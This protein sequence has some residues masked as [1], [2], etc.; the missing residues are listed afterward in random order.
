M[1][2]PDPI[3]SIRKH[4]TEFLDRLR[5]IDSKVLIDLV[6]VTNPEGPAHGFKLSMKE[7]LPPLPRPDPPPRPDPFK[8]VPFRDTPWHDH[9]RPQRPKEPSIE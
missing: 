9:A 6:I 2:D 4:A 7:D 5:K 8:D 3:A 1:N